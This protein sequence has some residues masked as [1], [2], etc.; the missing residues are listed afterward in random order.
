MPY[1]KIENVQQI[2]ESKLFKVESV[3]LTFS[4]GVKRTYERLSPHYH[5]S[6]MIVPM[7]DRETVLLVKEYSV[8]VE[9][10]TISFPKGLVEKDESLYEGANREL[11][12]EVGKGAKQFEFLTSMM[13][14]PNYMRHN[15]DIV[16]ASELYE[17]S[18]EGDEPEALEVIPWR[19]V[20]IDALLAQKNL[21]EAR[22]IAVALI[23][24]KRW[25]ENKN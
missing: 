2:A 22:S 14:S 25:L 19:L 6:V 9:D 13:L 5:R 1:P 16:I 10:Y 20:D 11:M 7:L 18:L 23:V 17:Q 15:I 21:V 24:W 12:E 3:D 8:G 4:N